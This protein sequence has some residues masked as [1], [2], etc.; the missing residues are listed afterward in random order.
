[1]KKTIYLMISG[2]VLAGIVLALSYFNHIQFELTEVQIQSVGKV[3]SSL[4]IACGLISYFKAGKGELSVWM[5]LVPL[6]APP[7][8]VLAGGPWR[9]VWFYLLIAAVIQI[10]AL[11]R[12]TRAGQAGGSHETHT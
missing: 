9:T 12:Y 11:V 1:M 3:L 10:L 6:C 7:A 8:Y 4:D 2:H 5:I